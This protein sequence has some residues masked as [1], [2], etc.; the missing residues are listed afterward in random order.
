MKAIRVHQFGGPE[1][2]KLEEV[3]KPEVSAGKILVKIHA[4][5]INPADTYV[6]SG[7]YAL[8]PNLPYTPGKDAAG[9]VESVGAGVEN[10]KVGDRVYV[11]DSITGTYAEYALC[12]P[13][14]VHRLADKVSFSQGA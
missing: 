10:V 11:G 14:Q 12:E 1:V 3:P 7:T 8:K 5:G 13:T 4:A 9:I 6:R 2:M